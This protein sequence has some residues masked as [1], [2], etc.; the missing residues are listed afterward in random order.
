MIKGQRSSSYGSKCL[1]RCLCLQYYC[2]CL[3]LL[4]EAS[5]NVAS[6][7][8][9][10]ISLT[11]ARKKSWNVIYSL[12]WCSPMPREL[13][14]YSTGEMEWKFATLCQHSVNGTTICYWSCIPILVKLWHYVNW[15]NLLAYLL[16]KDCCGWVGVNVVVSDCTPGL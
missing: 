15:F 11:C 12:F 3:A 16:T 7:R 14:V 8:P 5:V 9:W 13:G 10:T 2:T 4:R 1:S 6:N